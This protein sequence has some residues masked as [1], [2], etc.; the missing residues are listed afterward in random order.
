VAPLTVPIADPVLSRTLERGLADVEERLL[1]ATAADLAVE[2][3]ARHLVQAGGKRLRPLLTLLTAQ[4]G[5]ARWDEVIDAAAAVELTHMASLYH[6]DV[7]DSAPLRRGAPSAHEVFGNTTAILTGDL[8]FARTSGIVAK[9]GPWAVA[10]QAE[11]FERLCLGELH[12]ALGPL[13]G[14]DPL[15]HHMGVLADK[16]GSL[17]AASAHYGA[18]L[19]GCPAPVVQALVAYGEAVGVAFQLADDLIDLTCDAALTGKTPGT[20][21]RERVPTMPQLLVEARAR[22]DEAAGRF[23][24]PACELV[25]AIAGDLSDDAVL[26]SVV[27]RL[28]EDVAVGQAQELAMEWSRRAVAHLEPVADG[29]VKEALA[30]IADLF[31]ERL[32]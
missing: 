10:L 5:D 7:M 9:L 1:A 3:A 19:A 20:D 18:A 4:L 31:A 17:I 30:S 23:D 22:V 14:E 28:R 25:R 21:L 2:P 13:P 6:D 8:L 24:S 11:M 15:E 26:A 32:A 27:A 12:E 16:T 29:P